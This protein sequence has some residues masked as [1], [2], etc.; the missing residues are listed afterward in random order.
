MSVFSIAIYA[1]VLLCVFFLTDAVV[2]FIRAARGYDEDV[3]A[4]RLSRAPQVVQTQEGDVVPLLRPVITEP[5][6]WLRY[7]PLAMRLENLVVQSGSSLTVQRLLAVMAVV[8]AAVF[9]LLTLILPVTLFGAVI[10]MTMLC[11]LSPILFLFRA[12]AQRRRKFE[13]Q[14][15]DALDLIVRSLKVGHPLSG[16]MAVIADEVP[17]PIGTEFRI[18]C[19]SI[20]YGEDIT[21][22]FEKMS[23]RVPVLDLGYVIVAVQIQQETGGNLVESLSKLSAIIRERF[24]MF[25]KVKAVT[26][27]G[28]FSAWLLSIFPFVI[29]AG[30]LAVRPD[31]YAQVADYEYFPQLV[32]ITVVLLVVN[33]FI[34]R[35]L[36][37]IKV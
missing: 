19:D 31:Y 18:A 2:G 7:V 10:L 25:R 12:R 16:A 14:L 36:T 35:M 13:E 29:G 5:V 33:I 3:I 28:R 9:I 17:A 4:R 26:A 15:P 20:S 22:A 27:E 8:A 32:M 34:M 30:I 21:T 6:G 24:R 11:G 1:V 37:T 23:Q